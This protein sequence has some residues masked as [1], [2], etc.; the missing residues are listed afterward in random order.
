MGKIKVLPDEVACRIA[1]GEIVE[2]PASVVKELVENSIDALSSHIR[3][4]LR[5]GGRRLIAV[6]DDGEGMKRDDALLALERHAT[7][8]IQSLEDLFSIETLGFRGEALPS[9][10]AV[11][12]L[13][14]ITKAKDE[15]LGV[16]ISV[17]GGTL[18]GV[19]E[20]GCPQ[21]TRI[22]VRD[23][24]YNT[25]ARLK[26]MKSKNTELSNIIDTVQREALCY[27]DIGFDLIHEG[28]VL[29]HFRGGVALEERLAEVFPGVELFPVLGE[30]DGVKIYGFMGKPEYTAT[31][32]HKLYICVNRR[33]VRDR[34]LLRAVVDSYG[35][36]IDKGRFP[37]GVL[38]LE[39]PTEEVD[40]N[41]HP[42]KTEVRFRQAELVRS[43]VLDSI[44]RMLG[45][46]PW[47][48]AKPA[49][50]GKV[51]VLSYNNE[52]KSNECLNKTHFYQKSYRVSDNKDFSFTSGKTLFKREGFFSSLEIM[53]Q[54]GGLYIIAASDKGVV[55]IDQHAAHERVNFEKIKKS[56]VQGK[57]ETQE[58][59]IPQLVEFSPGEA[60]LFIENKEYIESM[61][62]GFEEFEN[63]SFLIRRIPAVL[64]P[65]EIGRLIKDMLYEV[66][67]L[68]RGNGFEETMD[69]LFST[70]ACHASVRKGDE[71]GREEIK[72]I[73]KE[74]DLTDFPH[75]CPHGRP[76]SIRISFEELGRMFKRI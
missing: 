13:R 54:L 61:G 57:L 33:P 52:L 73:L 50:E 72:A 69:R 47:I 31:T 22:E 4:E 7:S 8:K 11:S 36:M 15:I 46:V 5:G 24:F 28:K 42:T 41:V 71:L 17:D 23:L 10:A 38:F 56:Y 9:I 27:P 29:L 3:I 62:I 43:S 76:V 59:L 53:G 64:P 37:Q 60:Q 1:A 21:G 35:R 65:V 70:L 74:L 49:Y 6:T 45:C 75:S 39:V 58:L 16:K 51:E 48:T 55:I 30:Y 32:T 40:V 2:R 18:K 63:G 44:T 12:R 67:L 68:G 19:E 25:P 26:F 34:F 66:E 14:L 20:I